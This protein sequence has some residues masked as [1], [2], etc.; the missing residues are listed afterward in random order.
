MLFVG[1]LLLCLVGAVVVELL[2][3]RD[4]LD[5]GRQALDTIDL[6]T[7]GEQG[8]IAAIV[9]RAAD[10]ID[11]A[12]RRARTSPILRAVASVPGLGRQVDTVRD[13]TDAVAVVAAQGREAAAGLEAA[14]DEGSGPQGRIAVVRA[15]QVELARLAGRL[16]QIRLPAR[17]WLLPPL[18]DAHRAARIELADARS[19]VERGRRLTLALER[20]LV[21]PRRYLIL[22]GNNAEMRAVGIPTTSGVAMVADGA[23]EVGEFSGATDTIELPEP[24]V[25]VPLEYENV[26]GWLNG[27]RG[28]RTTLATANWPVA[29]RIAADITERNQYGSVDGIIY[30]DTVT[31]AATLRTIG[32]VEVNGV[33]YRW[34]NVADELLHRNYLRFPGP[35]D[36]PQRQAVQSG[37][38]TAIFDAM[39]DRDYDLLELAGWLSKAARGRHL[40]AW[41]AAEGE[42]E[43][44][45]SVGADGRLRSD[46]IGVV[47]QDL[48]ASKLDYFTTLEVD[49]DAE[50]LGDGVRRVTMS[51][52][53]TNPEPPESSP[54]IDGGGRYAEP[55]EYGSF[56]VAY[57]PDGASDITSSVGFT[58]HGP[59]GPMYAAG[60]ILRVPEGRARTVEISFS[61]FDGRDTLTVI[62]AAR[63]R[64]TRWLVDGEERL[65]VLPFE[66]DLAALD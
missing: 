21:G 3:I 18:A 16:G 53:I 10:R 29:A 9:D 44:W 61:L 43:L 54:Y 20:F 31:L 66:I 13:L 62:P 41:S 55:G 2:R 27:D 37:V 25:P 45:E 8:G 40:L 65:D 17:G 38:A 35:D 46:G 33:E 34:D 6:A 22:G 23:I 42:N 32:P 60:T 39:N 26:Y 57:L 56:L 19:D 28:Y 49:L 11:A 36:D 48:G 52:T 50:P 59:D 30:V 58:H 63:L 12:A 15:A 14:L 7:V 1:A 4:D 47:S 64:P 5:A 51:V 24:G